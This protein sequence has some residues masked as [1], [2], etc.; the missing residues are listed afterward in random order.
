MNT[1]RT[2]VHSN[3][4]VQQLAVADL[5]NGGDRVFLSMTPSG[6]PVIY[7]DP[8]WNPGN[9]KWWR[10]HAGFDPPNGYDVLLD[11]WCA[12]V[13]AC[14]PEHVFCEQSFNDRHR[15]MFVD[16]VDRCPGWDLP[17]LEEWTVYY[18]SPGSHGCSRPNALLH[19]GRVPLATDPSDLRGIHMTRC[20]FEG[21]SYPPGSTVG[22]PCIGKGM[23][24]RLAHEQGWNCVGIEL[25]GKRLDF[26][27]RW[28]LKKGYRESTMQPEADQRAGRIV[29]EIRLCAG[30]PEAER[31]EIYNR[32]SCALGSLTKDVSSDPACA[33]MLLSV[34]SV[35]G[36]DYNPNRVA[37]VEMDLLQ[38][39]IEADGV[40][41][42]IVVAPADKDGEWIVVD[43]F[44]RHMVIAERLGR[45]YLPC[46]V[47]ERPL[48]DRMA[49]TIR[50]NRARGK[51]HVDLMADLVK[52][53]MDL[54]W[55]DDQIAGGLGMSAEELL[56]LR[57]M[58]GAAKMLAGKEYSQS[59][60]RI[61]DKTDAE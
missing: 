58:V 59:W 39:S 17:L 60:G 26:A 50:H 57:Q 38:E 43:G 61:D 51:H 37:S 5:V 34:S 24:S 18:G 36:N 19:F 25:N 11:T 7:S 45:K 31:I 21:L 27:I 48:G 20:V 29:D 13:A 4:P 32:V 47:I 30:R 40:T 28:L 3:G 23:T 49:S 46:S 10:R 8:P 53:M 14:H 1:V 35:A 41:M 9:E 44:H 12:T 16:A 55:H 15:A 52:S 2:F 54:G 6:I 42:P 56:R 33:P 22:D